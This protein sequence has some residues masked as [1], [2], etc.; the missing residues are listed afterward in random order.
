MDATRV[1]K[2]IS[3][4]YTYG[5]IGN[6][7]VSETSTTIYAKVES[8]TRDEWF[9]AGKNGIKATYRATI[10]DFEYNGETVVEIDGQRLS[11]YRTYSVPYSDLIEL[12]LETQGGTE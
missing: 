4:T 7:I 6:E 2:L 5:D 9:S 8:I 3:R 11:V 1:I 10:Y 12:Y